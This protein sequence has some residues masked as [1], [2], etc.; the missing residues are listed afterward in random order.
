MQFKAGCHYSIGE[1]ILMKRRDDCGQVSVRET[2]IC[3]QSVH[4]FRAR[5]PLSA[6]TDSET[7]SGEE[8]SR[9]ELAGWACSCSLKYMDLAVLST[10][11]VLQRDLKRYQRFSKSLWR[12]PSWIS[13][14]TSTLGACLKWISIERFILCYGSAG[15]GIITVSGD[16]CFHFGFGTFQKWYSKNRWLWWDRSCTYFLDILQ[17]CFYILYSTH[18]IDNV[19][20]Y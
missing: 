12:Y 8:D 13:W 17:K 4:A 5:W 20:G 19:S 6:I 18:Y 2:R 15:V 10:S 1:G 9:N 14:I 7:D 16:V 3:A 11:S